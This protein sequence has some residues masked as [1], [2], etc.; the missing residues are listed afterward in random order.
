MVSF[1]RAIN[2]LTIIIKDPSDRFLFQ[3][4]TSKN[5]KINEIKGSQRKKKEIVKMIDLLLN[6]EVVENLWSL[7]A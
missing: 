5:R 4:G 6:I 3:F 1:E 7:Y 2:A